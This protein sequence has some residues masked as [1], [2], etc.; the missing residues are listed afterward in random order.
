MLWM[1][2]DQDDIRDLIE[3]AKAGCE[4]SRDKL[5]TEH[6]GFIKQV[7][8]KNTVG[9]E[10]INDREEY[11]VA[12]IAFNEAIDA[13]K[14]GLRSFRSFAA[15]VI[16]KRIIDYRRSMY[17]H[18]KRVIY[19]ED[20]PQTSD[21]PDPM[22]VQEK[23]ENRMEIE[24]FVKKLAC[25]GISLEKLV[26]ETPRHKDSRIICVRLARAIVG[27]AELREHFIKYNTI[28][29]K[30]LLSKIEISSKTVERHRKYI[31]ALCLILLSD[32]DGL[33]GYIKGIEGG[34]D[35]A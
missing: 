18:Q 23:I 5:I 17:R 29:L 34:D 19:M 14:P 32:L 16:R 30:E 26:E 24:A 20:N 31:I 27:D 28:P 9:Y 22:L 21:L 6:Q 25:F 2:T 10:D 15:D 13:Y 12:L 8:L 35:N 33:K 4:K 1:T 3:K 11:S 7:V